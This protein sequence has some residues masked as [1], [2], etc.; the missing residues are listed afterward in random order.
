[1]RGDAVT[2]ADHRMPFGKFKGT[3]LG[4]I[5]GD[6]LYWLAGIELRPRLRAAVQAELERRAAGAEVMGPAI[7]AE[8][9]EPAAEIIERGFRAAA[10]QHHPDHGGDD[11]RMR[12][13]LAARDALARVIGATP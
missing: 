10:R 12:G 3:P 1:M 5:D 7:P 11:R 4:E 8:L 2:G 13:V 6:Y 9:R